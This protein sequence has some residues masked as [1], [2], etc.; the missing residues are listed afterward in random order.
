MTKGRYN[1]GKF[2][3]TMAQVVRGAGEVIGCRPERMMQGMV[4]DV[5]RGHRRRGSSQETA[6]AGAQELVGEDDGHES[7]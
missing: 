6:A 3:Q 7:K 1:M 5:G 4:V 2:Q